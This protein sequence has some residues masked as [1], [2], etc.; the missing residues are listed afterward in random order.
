MVIEEIN[1]VIKGAT[2]VPILLDVFYNTT[3]EQAPLIIFVTAI[4]GLKTGGL[5]VY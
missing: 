2:A 1:K 4:K 5:G 3:V